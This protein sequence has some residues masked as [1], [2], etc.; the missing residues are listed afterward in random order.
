M[1][2]VS[3]IQKAFRNNGCHPLDRYKTP[4]V[5]EEWNQL[6]HAAPFHKAVLPVCSRQE[7]KAPAALA[8]GFSYRVAG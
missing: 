7:N 6:S 5:A 4:I 3:R 2:Q 1:V 8:D